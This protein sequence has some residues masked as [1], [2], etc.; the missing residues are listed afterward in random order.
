M[1]R[2]AN[3]ETELTRDRARELYQQES[4]SAVKIARRL[5]ISQTTVSSYLAKV[6]SK[7]KTSRKWTSE[8]LAILEEYAESLP[9][10]ESLEELA[11][12]LQRTPTAVQQKS[13]K[14]GYSTRS[15]LDN[16]T[17]TYLATN[18]GCCKHKVHRWIERGL[19]KARKT[20][21]GKY[22]I[23][24]RDFAQF[25]DDFPTEINQFDPEIIRWL[26]RK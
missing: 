26:S 17:L 12:K 13:S 19:L 2:R 18:L 9:L 5:G 24:A 22:A 15:L 7:R 23:K 8:D 4:L 21:L 20:R 1:G 6:R 3:Y 25:C 16:Y 14:L 10:E 11:K